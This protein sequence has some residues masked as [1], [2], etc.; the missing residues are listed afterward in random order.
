M[1]VDEPV[2]S[3][4]AKLRRPASSAPPSADARLRTAARRR[5]NPDAQAGDQY[6][7][8]RPRYRRHTRTRIGRTPDTMADCH[9]RRLS[10]NSFAAP[11]PSAS[12]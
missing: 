1:V 2:A 11:L 4:L 3:C 8:A 9:E 6:S 12:V 10:K 7:L 5:D